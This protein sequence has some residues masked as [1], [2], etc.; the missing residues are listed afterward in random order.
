VRWSGQVQPRFSGEYT[1]ITSSDDGIRVWVDGS[2]IIDDWNAHSPAEDSGVIN[3]VAGQK[4][5]IK[6]EY[7]EAGGRAVAQL[8][9]MSNCQAR[10]VIP[11]TQLYAP[12]MVC[13]APSIGS[14]TGLSGDYFDN[15]DF[16]N[17]RLS[18]I[19]PAVSFVW[20]TGTSP[21]TSIAPDSYSIRW[22]GQVQAK[23]SGWTTFYLVSDDGVRFFVDDRLVIDDWTAHGATQDV[24]TLDLVAGQ[25]YN[26][27]IEYY[28]GVG[29]GQIQL[30]WGSECQGR[31]ITPQTQLYQ[32]YTGVVCD[33]PV[34]AD[35]T[36]LRGDY[37]D[38]NDFTNLV[39]SH[40]AE[41]VNFNWADGS[42]DPLIQADTFSVRWTGQVQAQFTGVTTFS[43]V[44]DD[45]ARL[46]VDGQLIIDDWVG[47]SATEA[48]GTATL[49]A[50]QRYGIRLDYR[51]DSGN[52][53]VALYWTNACQ[54]KTL[55][56]A[57]QLYPASAP[58]AAVSPDGDA[59]PID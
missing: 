18:R 8:S 19:D 44:S 51:E 55:I 21:A 58:D 10:E 3:L 24:A 9:W 5:D 46:W 37:Y 32:T 41:A 12:A 27:R 1:F 13:P 59:S 30:L 56:P 36:G 2:L 54:A 23:Y 39:L 33:E 25:R 35:G 50:G 48:A 31:E 43:V 49:V 53:S 16:T 7:Y 4:Y 42:P 15:Q 26:L 14:G 22:T 17:K 40:E 11:Q 38:N 57:S 34:T 28:D 6:I 47:H 45:G 20:A 52:A 29:G